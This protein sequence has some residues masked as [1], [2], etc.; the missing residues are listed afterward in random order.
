MADRKI[1][2]LNAA[3]T[4]ITAADVVPLVQGGETVKA[5][6]ADILNNALGQLRYATDMANLAIRE[7]AGLPEAVTRISDAIN[8]L[9]DLAGLTARELAKT[10]RLREAPASSS[11]A[12]TAGEWAWDSNYIY[13]CTA[14]N[15]WKRVAI[16]TW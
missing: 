2:Q 6:E 15:T 3:P 11:A 4:A 5:T 16:T 9:N 8:H 13:V 1:S 7:A 12:G 10:A 14:L